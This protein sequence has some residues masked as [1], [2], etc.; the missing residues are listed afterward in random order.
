MEVAGSWL[1]EGSFLVSGR[2]QDG[3]DGYWAVTPLALDESGGDT[4]V[5]VVRGWTPEADAPPP[6]GPASLTGWL[7]PPEGT[8]AVDDDPDDDVVP[9]LRIADAVQRVDADLRDMRRMMFQG[10]IAQTTITVSCLVGVV[11]LFAF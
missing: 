6:A 1:G 8:G 9:Q 5:L 11:G 4:A 7:Q 2:T 10:F 3:R